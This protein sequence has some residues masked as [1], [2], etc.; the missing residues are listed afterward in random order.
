MPGGYVH[1]TLAQQAIEQAI[2]HRPGL[3][4]DDVRFALGYWKKFCIVGA[5]SPDYPYLD[6]TSGDSTTWADDMHKGRSAD[7]V[8]TAIDLIKAMPAGI[9]REKCTAWLFGFASH[10]AADGTIHPV[11]NI[12]VGGPYEQ[13]KTEHRRC[14]MSQDVH[15][16]G[17]LNLGPIDYTNQI[18]INISDCSNTANHNQLDADVAQM[19][20]TAL[21]RVYTGRP[22]PRI[23]D[24][25]YA[26][27]TVLTMAVASGN[28]LS[29]FM[30]HL[31]A[32]SAVV[33][34]AVPDPQYILGLSVPTGA[35]MDYDAIYDKALNNIVEL[36]GWMNLSLQQKP[37][38]LPTLA[39]WSLD[40]GLDETGTKMVYWS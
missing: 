17:R 18:C 10:M 3:L 2:Y 13:H 40:S 14:E 16:Y 21:M 15:A 6:L 30:R 32:N 19:W 27:R 1:I 29:P 20:Q 33:Y 5:V 11:V 25:H 39:N 8:R 26:M 37:S 35:P 36:W 28:L 9:A 34:P 12:K 22:A 4:S 7:F 31:A 24:W 23:H 38:P